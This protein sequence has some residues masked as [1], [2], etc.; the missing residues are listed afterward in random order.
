M[1]SYNTLEFEVEL[2]DSQ[3]PEGWYRFVGD[4]GTKMPT[5]RVPAYRCGT[6]WSGWLDGA[7]PTVEDGKVPKNVC[8]SDRSSGF[9]YSATISVKNCK[10]YFIYKLHPTSCFLRYCGTD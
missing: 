6:Y 4:A 8:F 7:H 2:C 10:S 9:K 3:L 1:R 5:T